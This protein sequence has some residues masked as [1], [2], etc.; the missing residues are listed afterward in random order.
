M[1]PK[2]AHKPKL[3][4]IDDL[5]TVDPMTTGQE[6]VFKGYKSGD[7]IVMS[8]SAGTGK[9]FTALY[10]ALEEVLDR[11]NQYSQVV[12]C[13]SIV[14]TREIGFLPGTLEEKMDAYTAPYK[15]IC[16]ELFDDSEAY[17]KLAENGSI[18]FISTSHIRGTTIN[19]A[20]IVVD[21]MQNLT[22]H[23]LDSIITRVGQNCK[24]IFCGD[25]YQSDFVKDGDKKGIIRFMDILEMMKGFTVVEF[26]WKDIVRSDFVRDYIM[27]KEM[28]G[29]KDDARR[30]NGER[31]KAVDSS[32]YQHNRGIP[33]LLKG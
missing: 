6:E 3:L 22:F 9:T 25:Y 30:P 31:F 16:A 33:E 26:T 23:E 17:S 32:P 4:R 10:L 15:T 27:T 12:V 11:G 2:L 24:I 5:L 21:E 14:P 29:D 28:I 20:V 1:K 7:H 13:R 18:E 8:G 19:D